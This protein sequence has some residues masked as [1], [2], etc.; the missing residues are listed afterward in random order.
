MRPIDGSSLEESTNINSLMADFYW[1]NKKAMSSQQAG[2]DANA[3][4]QPLL[5]S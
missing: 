4:S 5:P 2:D 3:G 1:K